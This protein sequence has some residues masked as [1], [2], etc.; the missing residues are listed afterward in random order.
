MVAQSARADAAS[1]S[2]SVNSSA[3]TRVDGVPKNAL[4]TSGVGGPAIRPGQE[5]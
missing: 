5:M 3:L 2:R 4:K 1:R